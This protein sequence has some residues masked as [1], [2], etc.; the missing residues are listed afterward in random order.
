M[1]LF[2]SVPL[3]IQIIPNLVNPNQPS[4]SYNPSV[5][6]G[7]LINNG[8][9]MNVAILPDM[10]T[11]STLQ[12]Q[13]I[14]IQPFLGTALID[15]GASGLA[16]DTSIA[17]NLGLKKKGFAYNQT[18]NGQR[19]SPVYFV[20]LTFPGTTLRSFDMLRATEVNLGNQQFR[21]LIG[22]ETMANW[23]IHYNGQTGQVSIAD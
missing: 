17:R 23:H 15:T 13:N 8:V 5:G 1:G 20:Q 6:A 18:A 12:S 19:V 11:V 22:R 9:I 14:S 3:G 10:L 16:I 7:I 4:I 2:T 21:C